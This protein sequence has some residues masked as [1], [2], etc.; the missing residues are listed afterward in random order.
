L[1]LPA[2]GY[3]V[4]YHCI[5]DADEIRS[6][7]IAYYTKVKWGN[8]QQIKAKAEGEVNAVIKKTTQKNVRNIVS[9]SMTVSL[10]NWKKQ[11]GTLNSVDFDAMQM[12]QIE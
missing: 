12:V 4:K 5:T 11:A 9:G 3:D 10:H 7:Y 8:K 2:N 1:N 6:A